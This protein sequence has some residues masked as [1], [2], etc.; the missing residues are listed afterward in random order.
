[1]DDRPPREPLH[2]LRR[3]RARVVAD[4]L[5]VVDGAHD[6]VERMRPDLWEMSPLL[7]TLLGLSIPQTAVV[8]SLDDDTRRHRLFELITALLQSATVDS[9]LAVVLVDL[10]WVDHSSLELI[11]HISAN[12]GS[13]RLAMCITTRPKEALQLDLQPAST[14][15]I[16]LSELPENAAM[17]LVRTIFNRPE[18][19]AQF[20][21]AILSKAHGNPLFLEE[22]ARAMQESG[23]LDQ[24]L[25]APSF[26]LAEEMASLEIPD[27]IQALMM[28]RIDALSGTTRDVLRTA[29]VI[30][31]TF[32]LPT[33]QAAL[34]FDLGGQLEELVNIDIVHQNE[35]I[36]GSFR[37]KHTL[38]QEVAYDNLPF[39]RRR[40]LHHSIASYLE[41]AHPEQLEPLY[42]VLVYHY[43]RS[44]DRSKT[45]VYALNAADKA[46]HVFA[47]E[48]S[49]EYY[50]LCL[51]SLEQ[52]G[53]PVA[54]QRS[55]LMERIG[56]CHEASGK[57]DQAIRDYSRSLRIWRNAI[58]KAAPSLELPVNLDEGIPEKVREAVLRHKI[59]VSY[60]RNSD[61]DS[62]LGWLESA[63]R[64]LPARQPS[65]AA[66]ISVAKSVSL[67]RKGQYEEAIRWGLRGLNVSRRGGDRGQQAYAHNMLALSYVE[68]GELK[69]AV[70]HRTV[71]VRLCE[72]VGD[73]PGQ[74]LANNNLGLCYQLLGDLDSALRYYEVSFRVC[75][76][77]GNRLRAAIAHNNIGEVLLTQ[78]NLEAAVEHLQVVVE[79]YEQTGD[80]LAATGLALVNMSRAHQLQQNYQKARESLEQGVG[81][82]RKAGARPLLTE[83][84]LQN[85]E[86]ELETNGAEAALRICQRAL[87]EA[88]ETGMKPLEARG[89]RVLGRID[90]ARGHYVQAET[91][92]R[93]SA[94]LSGRLGSDYERGLA[95]LT[96]A[97]LCAE[98]AHEKDIRRRGYTALKQAISIFRR[99]G[100]AMDLSKALGLEATLSR[101]EAGA[102]RLQSQ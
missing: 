13:F 78:G 100:A 70:R 26:R 52:I 51:T 25:N 95:L 88:R 59:G 46:R 56:D 86:L 37:F 29:A 3:R 61:Y 31:T 44:G 14:V 34:E 48:E 12:L 22:V 96:I 53:G 8:R 23:S 68:L 6:A 50:R 93:E 47:H 9:P 17:E 71:A 30:G 58:R 75:E 60:E 4:R 28:S 27:R 90:L 79:T 32:D 15:T 67:F 97:E 42:E 24:V 5:A 62:S 36:A 76:R 11:G 98:S 10:H 18:L 74:A 64:V 82:L 72:E 45:L 54:R 94:A 91:H 7:N 43:Q 20:V 33:L 80:P 102:K 21:K 40:K 2:A 63:L 35:G 1:L 57:H 89:L 101:P 83:A 38:V 73:L 39:A 65:Q 16:S 81:L 19:P 55:Y 84:S 66:Q 92:L 99:L 49:T 41:G 85:A 69:R 77:I 87:R